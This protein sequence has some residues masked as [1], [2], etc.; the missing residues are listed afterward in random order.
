[1]IGLTTSLIC[2]LEEHEKTYS[3]LIK[4]LS[5]K[6]S[7]A[8]VYITAGNGAKEQKQFDLALTYLDKALSIHRS[9]QPRNKK[10]ID[11]IQAYIYSVYRQKDV[12][13]QPDTV[14]QHFLHLRNSKHP[15]IP[16][17][18]LSDTI[19]ISKAYDDLLRRER[20]YA[21]SNIR[22]ATQ[23]Q[24]YGCITGMKFYKDELDVAILH[25]QKKLSIYAKSGVENPTV[26]HRIVTHLNEL[27]SIRDRL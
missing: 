16:D 20:Y 23:S 22:S 12:F 7:E 26:Y 25:L 17:E 4:R 15:W 21:A 5:D 13:Q 18:S 10:L 14:L 19:S 3:N 8:M 9:I 27:I 11:L 2:S 24:T 6:E 1:M